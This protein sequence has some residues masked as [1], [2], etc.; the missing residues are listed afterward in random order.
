MHAKDGQ[1]GE[2]M[3]PDCGHMSRWGGADKGRVELQKKRFEDHSPSM[4]CPVRTWITFW[5]VGTVMGPLTGQGRKS[6]D[7]SSLSRSLR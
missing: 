2:A 1:E 6:L 3:R 5:I 7:H 4:L